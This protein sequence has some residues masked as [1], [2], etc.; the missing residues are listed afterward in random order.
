MQPLELPRPLLFE[1]PLL[2]D[3]M[4]QQPNYQP[5][6]LDQPALPVRGAGSY[7]SISTAAWRTSPQWYNRIATSCRFQGRSTLARM[8]RH[9]AAALALRMS[10]APVLVHTSLLWRCL[11]ERIQ[12]AGL[13]ASHPPSATCRMDVQSGRASGVRE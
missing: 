2:F 11:A 6:L 3:R 1:Q 10:L 4:H 9:S 8:N 5:L 12:P 7:A 13:L